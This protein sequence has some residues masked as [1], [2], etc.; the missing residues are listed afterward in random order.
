MIR[1]ISFALVSTLAFVG[2]AAQDEATQPGN[3]ELAGENGQDGETAKADSVDNF[4]FLAV[5][6]ATKACS[7]PLFCAQYALE[8]VN[9]TTTKCFDGN[10]HATCGVRSI[11]WSKLHLSQAKVDKIEAAIE[12]E[13]NDAH[14]GTQVLVRGSYKVYVDVTA[15]E[16]SEVWLA[17]RAHGSDD[18]TFVRIFDRGIK[19]ITAPCPQFEEGKLNSTREMAIDGFDYGTSA[20]DALQ[21]RIY[22]A[23]SQPDGAIVVGSRTTRGSGIHRENLRT[24]A[25]A[26]LPVK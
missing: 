15:F 22:E 24:V 10:Y 25:Q 9:R 11:N 4:N 18:G 3:D 1:S 26:Y 8:R 6:A 19:C 16:A 23:T 2:C 5:H 20:E 13:A 12:A 14:L 7:N 21:E 17:Q